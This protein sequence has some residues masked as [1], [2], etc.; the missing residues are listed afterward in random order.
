M[1]LR[2]TKAAKTWL[3]ATGL[4]ALVM[5]TG[6]NAT[7]AGARIVSFLGITALAVGLLNVLQSKEIPR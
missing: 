7:G 1:P 4:A 6:A 5:V 3:I 2:F